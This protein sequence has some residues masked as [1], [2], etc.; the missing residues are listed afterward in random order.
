MT[1]GETPPEDHLLNAKELERRGLFREALDVLA[2]LGEHPAPEVKFE[3]LLFRARI[4]VR[5]GELISASEDAHDALALAKTAINRPC[6]AQALVELAVIECHRTFFRPARDIFNRAIT[7]LREGSDFRPLIRALFL[8]AELARELNDI[9]ASEAD[10]D[11]GL[12]LLKD[13]GEPSEVVQGL[14]GAAKLSQIS[15]RFGRSEE[16]LIQAKHAA[17]DTPP[18]HRANVEL[19]S[20]DLY[21][22]LRSLEEADAA[23]GRC[24][25]LA[26]ECGYL[27]MVP[28]ALLG[29]AWVALERADWQLAL[30]LLREA[31]EKFRAMEPQSRA[32][33]AVHVD[34]G[35]ARALLL[36][37]VAGESQDTQ[38]DIV[39]VLQCVTRSIPEL[40]RKPKSTPTPFSGLVQA[41]LCRAEALE[42]Q[43]K[44][45]DSRLALQEARNQ[46]AISQQRFLVAIVDLQ[47]ATIILRHY[48][49]PEVRASMLLHRANQI[50][51][52]LGVPNWSE[53]VRRAATTSRL[54]GSSEARQALANGVVGW[55]PTTGLLKWPGYEKPLALPLPQRP[56]FTMLWDAWLEGKPVELSQLWTLHYGENYAAA[57]NMRDLFR[58]GPDLWKMGIIVGWR[59]DPKGIASGYYTL[60]PHPKRKKRGKGRPAGGRP[61]G[62]RM[63]LRSVGR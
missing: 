49:S 8:R 6:Q 41:Y 56:L 45:D 47:E 22:Q 44:H 54:P 38:N 10:S 23:Y 20:G 37:I 61:P 30:G 17:F 25:K 50:F 48:H 2:G 3:A 57:P 58:A 55:D 21:L 28:Q 14:T 12:R 52:D 26:T 18:S 16:L 51:S 59:S 53:A 60:C 1:I 13:H 7:I 42:E 46:A 36:R 31:G 39:S 5:L 27:R 34:V 4:Q 33:E 11:E 40:E 15:E 9:S 32:P 43:K 29:K 24:E 63:G 62:A 19:F 35:M